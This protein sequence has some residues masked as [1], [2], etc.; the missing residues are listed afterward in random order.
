MGMD[1][2][3]VPACKAFVRSDFVLSWLFIVCI[4]CMEPLSFD[5]PTET[6]VVRKFPTSA[7]VFVVTST[8]T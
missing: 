3:Q 4:K 5:I 2:Y 7:N 1:R 6:E 8:R